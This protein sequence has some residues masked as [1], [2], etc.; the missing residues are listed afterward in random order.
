MLKSGNATILRGG[1]EAINSNKKIV[2]VL[3]S[4]LERTEISSDCIQ[5]IED[6]SR[7]TVKEMMKLNEYID[8]LIPRGGAGLIKS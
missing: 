2:E 6:T 3:K 4:A 1:S 5:L 7:E 8:V